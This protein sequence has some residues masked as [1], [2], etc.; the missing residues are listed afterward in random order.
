MAIKVAGSSFTGEKLGKNLDFFTLTVYTDPSQGMPFAQT[1]VVATR[2]ELVDAGELPTNDLTVNPITIKF[3]T[4]AFNDLSKANTVYNVDA[5]YDLAYA[6]QQN[7]DLMVEGISQVAQPVLMGD[8]AVVDAVAGDFLG[9]PGSG[10][11]SG[12]TG[13]A[14]VFRFAIEHRAAFEDNSEQTDPKARLVEEVLDGI[15]DA[16]RAAGATPSG[17]N[18]WNS[19]VAGGENN[20][21]VEFSG[22]L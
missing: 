4:G 16:L 2:D 5:D 13:A 21:K 7:F 19:D 15:G 18:T 17:L 22:T 6:Q 8:V 12:T 20:F 14:S 10:S 11:S 9:T 1:G 3:V